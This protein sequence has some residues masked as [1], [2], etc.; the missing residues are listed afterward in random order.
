[1]NVYFNIE[2]KTVSKCLEGI[3]KSWC[4]TLSLILTPVAWQRP[5]RTET[6]K[7]HGFHIKKEMSHFL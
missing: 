4:S 2:K 6:K 5:R 1:M 3:S 7:N